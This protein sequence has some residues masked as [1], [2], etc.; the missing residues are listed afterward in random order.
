VRI[1]VV[2]GLSPDFTAG[3]AEEVC[4]QSLGRAIASSGH[5][6]VNGCYNRFDRMVAEAAYDIARQISFFANPADAIHTYVSPGTKPTH[7]LGRVQKLNVSSWDPGQPD[8]CIPE[9]LLECDVLVVMGADLLRI[10]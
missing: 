2:G 5:V 7:R 6:L 9:P 10:E 3:S 8:W 1:L 4:A